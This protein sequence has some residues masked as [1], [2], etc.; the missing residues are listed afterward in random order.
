[1]PKIKKIL[2]LIL[3]MYFSSTEI[4][5]AQQTRIDSLHHKLSNTKEN[6]IKIDILIN[7]S[8]AYL[9][10]KSDSS[11]YYSQEAMKLAKKTANQDKIPFINHAQGLV[12]WVKG[13]LVE[14]IKS[15]KESLN[16]AQSKNLQRLIA[17][18]T[19]SI[20]LI[21]L[22]LESFKIAFNK[23][24]ESIRLFEELKDYRNITIS[25]SNIAKIYIGLQKNDSAKY[26]LQKT[27][28]LAQKYAPHFQ[29]FMLLGYAEICVQEKKYQQ[30]FQYANK[31][32]LLAQ[33]FRDKQ[34]LASAYKLLAELYF[35]ESDLENAQEYIQKALEIA[36][37]SQMKERLYD[38][39]KTY[40]QILKAKGDVIKAL[41]YH[42]LF[43]T[44]KDSVQSNITKNALK[45]F[46][47]ETKQG[48]IA[49]LKSKQNQQQLVIY[50][51]VSIILLI[52]IF[53][54]YILLSRQKIK[55]I[56]TN[57]QIAYTD[58]QYKQEEIVSQN[59]EL[60]QQQNEIMML[61]NQLENIIEERTNKLKKRNKQ[62]TEYAFF[63]AHKLRSPIAT[64]LGL[65]QLLEM[66]PNEEEIKLINEK[67]KIS[68]T[69]LDQMVRK[70][71]EMIDDSE[72]EDDDDMYEN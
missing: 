33:K 50:I 32:L 25:L 59:E 62:L 11:F 28:P 12:Y 48:E 24:Q 22:E 68:I 71:Q 58:I 16:E 20:G 43:V 44:Y 36:I 47:Y 60:K 3:L 39:Y 56:N 55:K 49:I 52:I 29:A 45:L 14:A 31:S 37:E 30:A 38:T 10:I 23:Y 2:S 34:D 67:I 61:N 42:E 66:N 4:S 17:L 13:D 1:M 27:M 5:F 19:Q 69:L 18:N 15:F 41:E 26:V 35:Y 7:M 57:L 72:E 63:N 40:S 65:Y 21:Y 8:S 51:I 9:F 64:I 54:I 46:E 53:T 70:S 6:N